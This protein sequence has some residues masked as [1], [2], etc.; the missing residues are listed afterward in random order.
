V[1][2]SDDSFPFEMV[3]FQGTF[4]LSR[5][6]GGIYTLIF[7]VFFVVGPVKLQI[8]LGRLGWSAVCRPFAGLPSLDGKHGEKL[9]GLGLQVPE[10]SVKVDGT[11]VN[12]KVNPFEH[13][14]VLH[15][16]TK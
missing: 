3:P 16:I 10:D 8:I 5:G 7:S 2:G 9:R 14:L 13:H 15:G 12:L 4:V 1:V 11:F 6:G